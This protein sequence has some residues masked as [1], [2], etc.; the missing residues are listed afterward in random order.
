MLSS[1]RV[2]PD[3]GGMEAASTLQA[4]LSSS[5]GHTVLSSSSHCPPL[6]V[7]LPPAPG[8]LSSPGHSVLRCRSHCPPSRSQ[9]PPL[10]VTLPSPLQVHSP[11]Q[12]TLSYAVGHTALPSR[13][14]CP[15]LQVTLPSPPGHAVLPSKS[16]WPQPAARRAGLIASVY[17][18]GEHGG[19]LAFFFC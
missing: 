8:P 7:I 13:S 12:V 10:L 19:L 1:F 6:L 9:S 15:T 11:L 5:P 4:T 14:H 16:H 3:A 18:E 17:R 2:L